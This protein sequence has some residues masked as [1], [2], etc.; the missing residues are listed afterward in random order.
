M[1]L[2]ELYG[3]MLSHK[4]HLEH[5]HSSFDQLGPSANIATHQ[6][7]FK[8]RGNRNGFSG[9]N[10]RGPMNFG[11]RGHGGRGVLGAGPSSGG[12]RLICQ[13]CQ[14]PGHT[15][16]Q[17]YCRFDASFQGSSAS[18]AQAYMASPQPVSDPSW[19]QVTSAN[20]HITSDLGNLTLGAEEYTRTRTV[21]VGGGQGLPIHHI[22]SSVFPSSK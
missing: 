1:T 19:Y 7:S 9:F 16:L 13:L 6:P 20:T 14:K 4:Q 21:Q 11:G 15:V 12:S 8:G 17:C 22:G 5:L 2:D 3:H 10:N 18:S